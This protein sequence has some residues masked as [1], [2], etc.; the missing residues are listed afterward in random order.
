MKLISPIGAN[1]YTD[2]NGVIWLPDAN[3][4]LDIGAAEPGPFLDEGFTEL[5]DNAGPT[6]AR[7]ATGLATGRMYFDTTLNKP[8]W[9]NASN[10]GWTDYSGAAV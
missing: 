6:S 9:R 2:P 4:I 5:P 1:P 3:G 7:P 8:I 10:T